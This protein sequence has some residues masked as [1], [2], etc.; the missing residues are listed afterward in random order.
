MKLSQWP[1][2]VDPDPEWPNQFRRLRDKVWPAVS[3]FALAIEHVGST[4]APG[5]AAKPVIDLDIVIPSRNEMSIA[6][7]QLGRIGYVHLGDLGIEDREAFRTPEVLPVHHLYVCPRDSVALIN[8]LALRDHLR[9][10]PADVAAY[11]ALKKRLAEQFRGDIDGYVEDKTGFILAILAQYGF[12]ADR[13]DS[14][15]RANQARRGV[16]WQPAAGC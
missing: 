10:H 3:D 5:L 12:T 1:L 4:S 15:R 11:A 7:A 6:V 16:G 14:I 2:V 13:L 8:H 9:A